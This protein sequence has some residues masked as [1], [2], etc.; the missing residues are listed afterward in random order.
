MLNLSA[1]GRVLS[2][3]TAWPLGSARHM[4]VVPFRVVVLSSCPHVV[5][6]K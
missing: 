2:P 3:C 6:R 4:E 1:A 5:G